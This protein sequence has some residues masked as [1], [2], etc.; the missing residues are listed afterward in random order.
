M[1]AAAEEVNRQI[2]YC[3]TCIRPVQLLHNK[4]Q[5]IQ[6]HC[7]RL[8]DR[9]DQ[10]LH[11]RFYADKSPQKYLFWFCLLYIS[12]F[13]SMAQS[14]V[15]AICISPFKAFNQ[16]HCQVCDMFYRF[17]H[18][19]HNFRYCILNK[20]SLVKMTLN[21][22]WVK[23]EHYLGLELYIKMVSPINTQA[24]CYIW[25][26]IRLPQMMLILIM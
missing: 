24:Y 12:I 2:S 23:R 16:T 14:I 18:D 10:S 5:F 22:L 15:S 26:K 4:G 25:D 21:F 11:N 7:N 20:I 13:F 6:L 17:L 9:S 19:S 1:R 8:Q 3:T